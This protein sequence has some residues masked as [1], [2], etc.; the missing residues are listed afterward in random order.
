MQDL[1]TPEGA[2]TKTLY[3]FQIKL[4]DATVFE[5]TAPLPV[6]M[7]RQRLGE[8]DPFAVLVGGGDNGA[9]RIVI[10]GRDEKRMSR[11]HLVLEPLNGSQVC[12][13]SKS[14]HGPDADSA[15]A[16]VERRD[17]FAPPFSL[18]LADLAVTV[19]SIEP[20]P[21]ADLERLCELTIGPDSL[22]GL[23]YRLRPLPELEPSQLEGVVGWLQT[24]LGVIQSALGS[25]DFMKHA[26]EALVK[27]VGLDCGHVLL[28]QDAN[29][30]FSTMYP[31]AASHAAHPPSAHVL[32]HVL[33]E[34][35]T[36]VYHPEDAGIEPSAS[37]HDLQAVVAAPILDCHGEVIGALYGER[38][39]GADAFCRRIGKLEG[40]LVE[41]LAC[42]IAAGLTRQRQEQETLRVRVR[43]EQFFTSELADHLAR[44]PDLLEG[45]ETEV[46]LLFC[47][48]RDF[49]RV[50]ARLG[51]ASTM[52]WI[53]EVMDA[54]SQCVLSEGGVLVDYVGDE[55]F[56]M[57]GAPRRQDDHPWRAIRAALA[58]RQV[59]ETM[60]AGWIERLGQILQVGIGINT[61]IAQVGN[62]GSRHKF[63]YGPLGNSVN[64]ASRVQGVT[65][66]LKCPVL[67][68][69]ATRERLGEGILSRR[70]CTALLQGMAEPVDLF[71]IS[72]PD[73][74]PG[75]QNLFRG[76][77]LALAALDRGDHAQ[78]AR[79]AGTLLLQHA[80]DGPLLAI[81]GEAVQRLQQD[82][83]PAKFIWR[84]PGK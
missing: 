34:K 27:I 37:L 8:P 75:Q 22:D 9:T 64:L 46:T 7:G 3:R 1:S 40:T 73:F 54:L 78:A 48:V 49:S 52:H 69:A 71:E 65:K 21:E 63:K 57:W 29:W 14:H 26:C 59:I 51:P 45:R 47:D 36:F 5:A 16:A 44:E 80:G 38:G 81:L 23:A 20:E 58:M 68:T 53:G 39:R 28:L 84:P 74:K 18:R 35:R 66:Y 10:G 60:S 82:Q 12:V 15:R 43:F 19:E 2:A 83:A 31:E 76:T 13:T 72:Q 77:E 30:Q 33:S 17:V 6:E 11:R 79:M 32:A 67:V 56:A 50:S 24:T 70:V 41:L 4:K 55:L 25:A 61:G 62:T 42:G